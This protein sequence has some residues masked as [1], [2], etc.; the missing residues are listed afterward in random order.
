MTEREW[1]KHSDGSPK[2]MGELSMDDQ[3]YFARKAL[4]QIER[5]LNHP[6]VQ[7]ILNSENFQS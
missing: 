1:P 4:Q 5:E 3:R 7:K 6:E 2:K